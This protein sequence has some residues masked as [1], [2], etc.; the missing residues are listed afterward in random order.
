MEYIVANLDWLE[1]RLKPLQDKS[2]RARTCGHPFPP[3]TAAL[4]RYVLFDCPGQVELYTHHDAMV[5]LTGYMHAPAYAPEMHPFSVSFMP[6][7][8]RRLCILPGRI[9]PTTQVP[10]QA[11]AVRSPSTSTRFFVT[12]DTGTGWSP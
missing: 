11:A 6:D 10:R 12:M 8:L 3:L 9:S 1:E 7:W 5:T 4:C 2:A